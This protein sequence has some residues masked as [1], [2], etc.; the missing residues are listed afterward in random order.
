MSTVVIE[1]GPTTT[2]FYSSVRKA[3]RALSGNGIDATER[4]RSALRR[5]VAN[6]GGLIGNT[7]V[8]VA[9]RSSKR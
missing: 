5:R 7:F 4:T 3:A 1:R 6:G 2:R 8:K 9:K